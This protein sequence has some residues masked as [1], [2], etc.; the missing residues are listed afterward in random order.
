MSLQVSG[1]IEMKLGQEAVNG[2]SK[3]GNLV[4]YHETGLGTYPRP[5]NQPK[6]N[7]H[8]I[9]KWALS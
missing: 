1:S 9:T 2:K 3:K 8:S 4:L 6:T 7:H 5:L